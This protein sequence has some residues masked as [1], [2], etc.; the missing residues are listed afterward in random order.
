VLAHLDCEDK[1]NEIPA[2]QVLLS[3]LDLTQAL[4][5]VDAMHCQ[6]KP[7]SGPPRPAPS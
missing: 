6:K 7:S 5:T 2:V 1:S 3:E 4:V